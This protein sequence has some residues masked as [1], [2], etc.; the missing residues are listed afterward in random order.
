MK[1]YLA[2]LLAAAF[3][4]SEP[5]FTSE[6]FAA[7]N[8]YRTIKDGVPVWSES[9][10]KSTRIRTLSEGK[11]ITIV[12]TVTNSYGNPWGKT[13]NNTWIY[14]GNLEKSNTSLPATGLYETDKED[15]PLRKIPAAKETIIKR[16]VRKGTLLDIVSVFHNDVGNVWGDTSDGYVVF[17]G[18]LIKVPAATYDALSGIDN[19]FFGYRLTRQEA[20]HRMN[21]LIRNVA[22][23]KKVPN[24]SGNKGKGAYG[25]DYPD[26]KL[27]MSSQGCLHYAGLV[28]D[29]MY[30]PHK[31][32]PQL[33][34]VYIDQTSNK[35]P[36]AEELEAFFKKNAQAGE[37]LRFE[38]KSGTMHSMAFVSCNDKGLYYLHYWGKRGDPELVYN[39]YKEFENYLKYDRGGIKKNE[40]WIYDIIDSPN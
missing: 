31:P 1:R 14:M 22:N 36:T 28:T 5:L 23:Y 11:N 24:G 16:L 9:N 30:G 38:S 35:S 8:L 7:G 34:R 12:S 39:T 40:F 27:S 19:Q 33:T 17:M 37:H 26:V 21:Y 18:N 25:E 4:F 13:R 20:K 29:I 32:L 6:A 3:L 10:S 15:V 2:L